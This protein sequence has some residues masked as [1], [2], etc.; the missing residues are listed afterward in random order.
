M[1]NTDTPENL[2]PI[3][4]EPKPANTICGG[5]IEYGIWVRCYQYSEGT[6]ARCCREIMVVE[7]NP[8]KPEPTRKLVLDEL[9]EFLRNWKSYSDLDE[10]LKQE[11]LIRAQS[12][13]KKEEDNIEAAYVRG[14]CLFEPEKYIQTFK[15]EVQQQAKDYLIKTYGNK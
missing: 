1:E 3:R 13:R 4:E 9:I 2:L 6:S 7:L 10:E 12:L 14:N 8:A 5:K 11:T 15:D